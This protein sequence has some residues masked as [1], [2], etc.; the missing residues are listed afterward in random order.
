MNFGQAIQTCM[1]KY[2]TFEGRASRS[3]FWWFYLFTVLVSWG[4]SLVEMAVF[5]DS[6]G[7]SVVVNLALILPILAAATRRLHD[8]GRS[9]W[10]Q[11]LGLTVIGII[12][13]VVWWA[14]EGHTDGND[15]GPPA[16]S[17]PA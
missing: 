17:M 7:L 8:T 14:S 12:F 2:A 5:G 4:A 15:Y 1:S 9:G 10:W 3:E 11:L 6:A 13:L 16:E